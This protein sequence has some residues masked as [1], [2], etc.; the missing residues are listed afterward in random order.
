MHRL[1]ALLDLAPAECAE[2][3]TVISMQGALFGVAVAS[4]VMLVYIN[5]KLV[6]ILKELRRR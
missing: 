3:R 4:W 1:R 2:V 5:A 6:D